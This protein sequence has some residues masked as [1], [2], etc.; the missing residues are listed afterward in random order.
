[1]CTPTVPAEVGEDTGSTETEVT[2]SGRQPFGD[3]E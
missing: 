3:W 2:V 1:M